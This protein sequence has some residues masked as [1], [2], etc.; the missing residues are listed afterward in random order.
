M[1]QLAKVE[2]MKNM[3]ICPPLRMQHL[4]HLQ[5][6]SVFLYKNLQ[7]TGYYNKVF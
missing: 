4:K 7:N 1:V 5:I 6:I 2:P 3:D